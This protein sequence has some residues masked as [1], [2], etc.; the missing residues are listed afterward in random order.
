MA[1]SPYGEFDTRQLANDPSAALILADYLEE[2]GY[3]DAHL[4][5]DLTG[6]AGYSDG[7]GYSYGYYYG[8]DLGNYGGHVNYGG[9]GC[10]DGYGDGAGYGYGNYGDGDGYGNGDA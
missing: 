9:D 1:T 5:R 4:L 3:R 2:R 7:D 6:E 8:D 10:G